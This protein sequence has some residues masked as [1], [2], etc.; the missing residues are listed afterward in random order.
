M[1]VTTLTVFTPTYNRAHTLARLFESLQRQTSRDF[2]WLVVDD[3][4]SDDTETL[5]KHWQATS[6]FTV[7]YVFQQNRGKH[8]AHNAAVARATTELFMIVDSDDE[9]LPHAVD[10]ITSTWRGMSPEQRAGV[11]GIWTL[12]ADPAGNLIGG[13]FRRDDF[14]ASLQELRY[15][16]EVDKEMLPTFTTE[17]LRR[18]PF[19]ETAPGVCPWIP[20][21]YVW[22]QITRI[23]P[24][25]FLNVACRL[26]HQGD[27]LNAMARSEYLLS[28]CI[29]FGYLSPLA[30]E[31]AWFRHRPLFFIA[32]AIQA[33]RYA[34]FCGRFWELARPL[35]WKA[36]ALL[37]CAAPVSMALLARDRLS[38]RIAREASA[39][40][41]LHKAAT[42]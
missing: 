21:S 34:I 7:E 33:A 6:N 1:T 14:Y 9:L 16:E 32:S 27:G 13:P 23:R 20:E 37:L 39:G 36:Q 18:H 41:Q 15:L 2:R 22:M 19:P 28:R 8:C 24:L 40:R 12:C 17:M 4:S 3:G 29:V 25:R 42:E 10:L 5:V 38:G 31:L 11:A 35:S 26:Y 30:N